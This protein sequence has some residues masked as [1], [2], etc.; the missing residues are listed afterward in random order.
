MYKLAVINMNSLLPEMNSQFSSFLLDFRFG[1]FLCLMAYPLFVF[2][3]M[4]KQFSKKNSR[5]TI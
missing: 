3:L 1:W 5:G 2:Y 4:P